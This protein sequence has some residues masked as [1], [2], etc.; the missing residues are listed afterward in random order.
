VTFY[1]WTISKPGREDIKEV[2]TRPELQD[3]L[4]ILDLP[5]I[6]VFMN[7]DQTIAD[8]G[9]YTTDEGSMDEW[10]LTWTKIDSDTEVLD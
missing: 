7:A 8:H 10:K 4:R 9:T 2:T 1:A 3:V 5:G 6:A